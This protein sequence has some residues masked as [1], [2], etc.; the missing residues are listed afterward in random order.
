MNKAT[1]RMDDL[2]GQ[3]GEESEHTD[4]TLEVEAS[5]ALSEMCRGFEGIMKQPW[6]DYSKCK[7]YTPRITYTAED[8]TQFSLVLGSYQSI[9]T[10]ARW[11]G[12]F[13][14]ALVNHCK[15]TEV[16]V[17]TEDWSEKLRYLGY[18]NKDHT[19]VVRGDSGDWLGDGMTGGVIRLEG[20]YCSLGIH[21]CGGDIYHKEIQ[22]IENGESLWV[23]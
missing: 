15:D 6:A 2:L 5:A 21:I 4:R 14:S 18:K 20:D 23:Q 10:F 9:D 11:A 13:M 1:L 22:I 19:L 7:G 8:V 12:L 17:I 3:L 16:I